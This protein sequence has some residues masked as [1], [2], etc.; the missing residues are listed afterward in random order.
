MQ[1]EQVQVLLAQLDGDVQVDRH[2]C[3]EDKIDDVDEEATHQ[4]AGHVSGVATRVAEQSSACGGQAQMSLLQLA[5]VVMI[6][7]EGA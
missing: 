4:V 5:D 3:V 7:R 1:T 6:G 2:G